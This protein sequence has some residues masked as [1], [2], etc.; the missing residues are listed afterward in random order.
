MR[1][2][3]KKKTELSVEKPADE[4]SVKNLE[5]RQTEYKTNVNFIRTLVILLT[6]FYFIFYHVFLLAMSIGPSMSPTLRNYQVVVMQRMNY[7]PEHGDI[8]SFYSEDF[9]RNFIKRVIGV[10]GDVIDIDFEKGIVYRNG[11][12]L[13]ENY[14]ACPTYKTM[15]TE[16]PLTVQE[17][18]VF[19]LGDNRDNSRDSRWPGLAQIPCDDIMGGKI[20]FT[21]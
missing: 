2:L 4:V 18:C 8:V 17:G 1:N 21:I 16:F 5:E 3:T 14:A 10:E 6:L 13:E 19:C 9:H 11:E 12:A 20:I 15:G 7:T